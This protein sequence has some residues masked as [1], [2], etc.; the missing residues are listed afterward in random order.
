M[1]QPDPAV[2]ELVERYRTAAAAHDKATERGDP[3]RANA[4]HDV[5]ASVYRELRAGGLQSRLL[6][7]LEDPYER[8]RCW[9]AAHALE[10]APH[11]GEPVLSALAQHELGIVSFD[12]EMTPKVWREGQLRFP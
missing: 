12:A 5:V 8:V 10:F 6:V 4:H 3:K 11:L 7:L 1:A 2:D 9:A